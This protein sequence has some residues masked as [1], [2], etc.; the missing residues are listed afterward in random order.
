MIKKQRI[1]KLGRRHGSGKKEI[2]KGIKEGIGNEK[3]NNTGGYGRKKGMKE[4][5]RKKE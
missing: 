4:N 1:R 3:I 5:D 2:G